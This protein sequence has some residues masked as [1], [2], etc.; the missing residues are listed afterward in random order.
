MANKQLQRFGKLLQEVQH[1]H[2]WFQ[3]REVARDMPAPT[4]TRQLGELVDMGILEH[5]DHRYRVTT[6]H[7]NY[8]MAIGLAIA[9]IR[10][11]E[12]ST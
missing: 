5:E 7:Q 8:L 10:Y 11:K 6:C 4:K 3:P 12:R 9:G 2:D 1:K